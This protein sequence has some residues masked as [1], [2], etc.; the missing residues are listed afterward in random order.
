MAMWVTVISEVVAVVSPL[1]EPVSLSR[2]LTLPE[3]SLPMVLFL[4][5]ILSVFF[6]LFIID[7]FRLDLL[8]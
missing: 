3:H 4:K 7:G 6:G 5:L 8:V 1:V 2:C